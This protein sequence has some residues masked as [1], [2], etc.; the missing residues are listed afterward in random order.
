M[1][2]LYVEDDQI[3]IKLVK[4]ELNASAGF[5]VDVATSCDEARSKLAGVADYDAALV[6][7]RLPDGDGMS[8]VHEIRERRLPISVVVVTGFGDEDKAVS[9]LKGGADDYVVKSGTHYR[10]LPSPCRSY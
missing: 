8:L 7:L 10:E 6:D 9:A 3:D 2:I 4:H 5:E 1:K